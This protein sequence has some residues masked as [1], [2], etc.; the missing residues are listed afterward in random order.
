MEALEP[1]IKFFPKAEAG[2]V[3]R[4]PQSPWKEQE[5]GVRWVWEERLHAAGV[6]RG[7]W[8]W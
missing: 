3:S 6:F 2:S 8:A 5:T 1:Y 7:G 4:G